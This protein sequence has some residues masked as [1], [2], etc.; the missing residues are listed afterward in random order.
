MHSRLLLLLVTLSVNVVAWSQVVQPAH[1]STRMTAVVDGQA[2]VLFMGRIDRGWHVYSTG[3]GDEGPIEA[4]FSADQLKGVSV[5]GGLKALGQ[6]RSQYDEMF[7]MKVRFFEDTVTFSQHLRFEGGPWE[8]RCHLEYG[9]CNNESCL[10]PQQVEYEGRGTV[11]LSADTL[12]HQPLDS[13]APRWRPRE[14]EAR[15]DFPPA[16]WKPVV[17]E[18]RTLDASA[19]NSETPWWLIFLQG[20]L[21]GLLA[22]L[23]PCV[24]P[25][26][27]L[28][29]SV[30]LKR[31]GSRR[32]AVREAI[33][34]GL[35]IVGLFMALALLVTLL[36]GPAALNALSTNAIFNVALCVLLIVFAASFLGAFDLTLPASWLDAIESRRKGSTGFLAIFFMALTLVLVSFSCT[37]PIIGFLLVAVSQQGSLAAPAIGILGFALALA[38]PFALF[39]LFPALMRRAP[40]A[41]AWLGAVKVILAFIELA[42]ALKFLSVADLAYGWHVLDR[43]VF[44][45]LWIVLA[46][47]LG[48][49]LLGWLR[50][51]HEEEEEAPRGATIAG[52]FGGVVCLAF[53]FYMVP[54]LWGAPL[55]A[56][57]AFTP[58]LNTQDFRL[59]Q[60]SVQAQYH[61]YDQALQAASAEGKPVLLDFTG[62]GCVNCRKMEAAVWTDPEVADL[63]REHF[64]LVSLYVDD[65][66]PLSETITVGGDSAS[67]TLRSVG[68]KWSYLQTH[69]FGANA[70]PFYVVV[71]SVG[72]PL[73]GSYAY[74]ED[75][76]AYSSWLRGALQLAQ[77][78]AELAAAAVGDTAAVVDSAVVVDSA[79]VAAANP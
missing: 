17:E 24:W 64:T 53:G 57:S 59:Q 51:R 65:K 3:L 61:D 28:T 55:K 14:L 52:F 44:L 78:R 31:G 70:Q 76:G 30:F 7:G 9:I 18:M 43:E 23:T 67:L 68:Q 77:D 46:L 40:K 62:Y 33:T 49:Y 66:A 2:D 15:T 72:H 79:I 27:P 48:C 11:D 39:A 74:N 58:P 38:I 69:K 10:P 56:I 37:G 16:T 71:D 5:V 29:V 75:V 8:L 6:E 1:F 26:I 22:L 47:L 20:M 19:P 12:T 45:A 60:S 32:R 4:S 54:G 34:Y 63:I 41:G 21:G 25:I 36:W 13:V 73:S 35:C 50:F 42:F